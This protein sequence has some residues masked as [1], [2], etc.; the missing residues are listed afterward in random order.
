MK[1][2]DFVGLKKLLSTTSSCKMIFVSVR[3]FVD[4]S[5]VRVGMSIVRVGM[6]FVWVGMGVKRHSLTFAFGIA[7]LFRCLIE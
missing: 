6:S 1:S 4:L 5:R 7:E 2:T 3:R